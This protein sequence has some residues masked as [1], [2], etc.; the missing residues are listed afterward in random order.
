MN[1]SMDRFVSLA[2]REVLVKAVTQTTPTFAIS[3][4]KFS[5]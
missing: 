2:G 4:F 5:R 3:V 1:S